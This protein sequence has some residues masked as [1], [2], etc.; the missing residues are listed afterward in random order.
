M[1][2]DERDVLLKSVGLRIKGSAIVLKTKLT[3]GIFHRVTKKSMYFFEIFGF[4]DSDYED[5]HL[6][7]CD[8]V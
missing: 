3:P 5:N 2:T 1:S 7:R 4:Q 8:T 6:L